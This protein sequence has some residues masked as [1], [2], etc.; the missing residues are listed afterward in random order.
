MPTTAD[1][2]EIEIEY[3]RFNAMKTVSSL[4]PSQFE[5]A[6]MGGLDVTRDPARN[7]GYY[8][9]ILGLDIDTIP[10]VDDA[11]SFIGS[12]PVRV[13]LASSSLQIEQE[14]ARRH[15]VRGESFV[16]LHATRKR[17]AATADDADLSSTVVELRPDDAPA[18]RTLL[19]VEGAIDDAIWRAKQDFLFCDAFRWFA[20]KRGPTLVAAASLWLAKHSAV[21]GS[22]FTLPEHRGAGHQRSLIHA[23]SRATELQLLVDVEPDS[24]SHRNCKR[25]GF[26]QIEMRHSWIRE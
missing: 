19:E 18:L 1:I 11:L 24:T 13:D 12:G 15:F 20:I 21:F 3:A 14:L 26:Q 9:R 16:W 23:R 5:D 25:S 10:L 2:D 22:A 6:R 17:T 7:D 4:A 8:N